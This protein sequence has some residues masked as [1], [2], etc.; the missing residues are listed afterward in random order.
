MEA[1]DWKQWISPAMRERG[2]LLPKSLIISENEGLGLLAGL[3]TLQLLKI[4]VILRKSQSK[5][6]PVHVCLPE[7][8]QSICGHVIKF[9]AK[10]ILPFR[11]CLNA[12]QAELAARTLWQPEVVKTLRRYLKTL[13]SPLI[14]CTCGRQR[15]W[16][17]AGFFCLCRCGIHHF[18]EMCW[19]GELRQWEMNRENIAEICFS[20]QVFYARW[21]CGPTLCSSMCW[22]YFEIVETIQ[23]VLMV[24][25]ISHLMLSVCISIVI[26][27][28]A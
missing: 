25:L 20:E 27:F 18:L 12:E 23:V 2:Y 9:W 10:C 14:L 24:S 22:K 28:T 11:Y 15:P 5:T 1:A 26:T 21:E 4:M 8:A 7:I 17:K 19:Y 16:H 13:F 6:V 3:I